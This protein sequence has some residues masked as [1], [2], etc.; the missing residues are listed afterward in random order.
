MQKRGTKCISPYVY[1]G[2]G[3]NE[4][5]MCGPGT[6]GVQPGCHRGMCALGR[7]DGRS[8][9]ELLGLPEPTPYATERRSTSKSASSS[10]HVFSSLEKEEIDD[11]LGDD[12]DNLVVRRAFA[13]HLCCWGRPAMLFCQRANDALANSSSGLIGAF[14]FRRL[15]RGNDEEADDKDDE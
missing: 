6:L 1:G 9:R 7:A 11:L 15:A 2:R 14:A 12:A 4:N 10:T 5:T 3:Q 8:M 13:G